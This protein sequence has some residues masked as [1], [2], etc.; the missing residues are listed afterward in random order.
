M[1]GNYMKHIWLLLLVFWYIGYHSLNAYSQDNGSVEIK[2]IVK[3]GYSTASADPLDSC[4]V[5]LYENQTKIKSITTGSSG[6]YSFTLDLNKNYFITFTKSGLITKKIQVITKVPAS[7]SKGKWTSVFNI[8]LFDYY[9]GIDVS[10]LKQPVAKIRFFDDN[11]GGMFT[12]DKEYSKIMDKKVGSI[13]QLSKKKRDKLQGLTDEEIK[14]ILEKKGIPINQA[15]YDTAEAKRI[16]ERLDTLIQNAEA[17]KERIITDANKQ[18]DQIREKAKEDAERIAQTLLEETEYI[19][20]NGE[21]ASRA[22]QRAEEIIRLANLKAREIIEA[23]NKKAADILAKA[24]D[25]ELSLASKIAQKSPEP[26]SQFENLSKETRYQIENIEEIEFTEEELG[27]IEDSLLFLEKEIS[28]R[29]KELKRARFLLELEKLRAKTRE[30]SIRIAEREKSIERAERDLLLAEKEIAKIKKQIQLQYYKIRQQRI[31]L[32]FGIVVGIFLIGF[33]IYLYY[34]YRKKQRINALLDSQNKEIMEKNKKIQD[35]LLYAKRIQAAIL[36]PEKIL[37][38]TFNNNFVLFRPK[39]IV[40]GDFYWLEDID[41]RIY[42]SVVDCTG[43]GVPGAFMSIIGYNSLN[44]I[45]KELNIRE[46]N[47]ILDHLNELVNETLRTEGKFGDV[48][49]GMDLALCSINKECNEIEFAGAYNP[50]YIVREKGEI[51]YQ[52]DKELKP[53]LESNDFCLYE[54]KAT[55]QPIGGSFRRRKKYK[56]HKIKLQQN[57]R[58]YVFSDGYVDQFGGGHDR[59]KMKAKRFKEILMA[60]QDKPMHIQ[61]NILDDKLEEWRGEIEQMDDICIFGININTKAKTDA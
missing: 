26:F 4:I 33:L 15:K 18:A 20:N 1:N 21:D 55:K 45:L 60:I 37:N 39:D 16:E 50:L 40:S 23:A 49:D 9:P 53:V 7:R 24:A 13:E 48:N 58:L 6:R 44:K 46:P 25:V 47:A 56:L 8:R 22:R 52:D 41:D 36:P 27:H 59:E 29:K 42:F 34:N 10:A 3:S 54:I 31:I 14:H 12:Y 11:L 61:R 17:K 51:V 57:D 19:D 2:G 43:H 28:V 32:I 30:D 35:S 38:S 5:Q